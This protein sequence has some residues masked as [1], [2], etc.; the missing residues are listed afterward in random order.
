MIL[1]S[2]IVSFSGIQKNRG[3]CTDFVFRMNALNET[4][5][6]PTIGYE[7]GIIDTGVYIYISQIES[8]DTILQDHFTELLYR[9]ELL[10]NIQRMTSIC[11][12][13]S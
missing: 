12:M 6:H 7:S 9:G 11:I 3:Q 10:K 1:R 4:S 5:H 13:S 8:L 2:V